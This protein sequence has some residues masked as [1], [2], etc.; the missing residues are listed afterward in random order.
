VKFVNGIF[1]LLCKHILSQLLS[2]TVKP[3]ARFALFF[4]E[5]LTSTAQ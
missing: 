1:L 4:S 5:N 2:I 3:E